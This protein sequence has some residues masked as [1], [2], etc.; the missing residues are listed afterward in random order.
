MDYYEEN[1]QKFAEATMAADMA[2]LLSEF[3][4]H[5][6]DGAHVLDAG[7]G[8]GRDILEFQRRGYSVEAFDNSKSMVAMARSQTGVSVKRATF[9]DFEGSTNFD[10]VWCCASLLHV[11]R[12]D[13]AGAVQNLVNLMKIGAVIYVSFKFGEGERHKDNRHF[14]DMTEENLARLVGEVTGLE[15]VKVWKTKDVRPERSELW[16]NAIFRRSK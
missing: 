12:Q 8:P 14:T 9:L 4:G 5:L 11:P 6:P 10:G 13:L 15:E 2:E 16:L 1:A 7:C 3:C